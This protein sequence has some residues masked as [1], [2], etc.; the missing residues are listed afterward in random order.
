M[1]LDDQSTIPFVG[2]GTWRLENA[3]Y[4]VKEAIVAGYR[5][6]DCAMVYQNEADVGRALS[7]CFETGLVS[8][9]EMFITS[10]EGCHAS[11]DALKL[12]YIDLY[13]MHWPV[14]YQ[15]GG[16][17]FPKDSDGNILYDSVEIEATWAAMESLVFSGLVKSIG[18]SNFNIIQI[19]RILRCARI[20]PVML[21]LES[22]LG[23]PNQKLI[24]FA[25]SIG[26]RVTA[27]SPLGSPANYEKYPNLL[28]LPVVNAL[29]QKHGKTPAQV[30]LR[31]AIQRGLCVVPKSS[32]PERLR[33]N[34][35]I[36]DFELPAEDIELLEAASQNIRR[37]QPPLMVN[38][39]EFPF[40][41][42]M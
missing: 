20:R 26:L 36:F 14:S 19:E 12:D 38:H 8:R 10:K 41:Q 39:P 23:F 13:L 30:L 16:C 5:H 22:H 29:S 42:N 34:L 35:A 7:H 17:L 11:L 6:L 3:E 24:D 31:H 1:R 37:I 28:S 32:N 2:L 27:Y 21:Q 33:E 40:K 15:P 25:H 18:L 9:K 4:V